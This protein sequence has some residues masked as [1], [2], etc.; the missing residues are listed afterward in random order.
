MA[1]IRKP[2]QG[3]LDKIHN[4][5]AQ[6][7]S[8]SD[9]EKYFTRIKNEIAGI[10]EF[11]MKFWVAFE[12]DTL[13]IVGLSDLSP[14][15][16]SFCKTDKPGQLKILYIDNKERGKGVGKTLVKF[17]E[18]E[19]VKCGYKE[20]LVKSAEIYKDTAWGF[21]EKMGYKS[22]GSVINR[23]NAGKSNVFEK[24]LNRF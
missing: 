9:T 3:D 14:D 12:A 23:T 11:N 7:N 15:L 16:Y 22:E 19:A 20:L 13:G 4:I 10:N 5:L 8:E 6:W 1:T 2:N 21:Y 24:M 17:I 18:S